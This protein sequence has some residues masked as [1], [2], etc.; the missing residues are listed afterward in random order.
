MQPEGRLFGMG[1]MRLSTEPGR[2]EDR[3]VAVLQAALEAGVTLLDTADAYCHDET[4]AGHNERLI[5]RALSTWRGEVARIRVAT[6]GGLTRPGGEWVPDGRARHLRAACQRSRQA[7]GVE[8]IDLYLLHAPDP[9]T[10]LKTSVRA[11]AALQAE[12]WIREIGLCNVTVRQIEEAR[13]IAAIRAVQVEMSPW[14]EASF[15]NG[16]AEHC[17]AHGIPLLAHRPLGGVAGCARLDRDPVVREVATRHGATPQEIALAWL[18]DLSPALVPLPG[19]TRVETAR[20]LA[21]AYGLQLT[22]ED[23]HALDRRFPASRL[24]RRSRDERRPAEGASGDVVLVMGLPAAGKSTVAE[25]LVRDGYARLNRDQTGGRLAGLLP[26]LDRTLAAGQRRIV[27]DNTYGSRAVRNAVIETAWAHGVPVRC[28]WLDTPIED[29]Q[30]N[31]AGRLLSR[32]GRLLEPEE[33][34]RAAG[35]DP[36]AFGPGAQFR[37]VR[38]LEPPSPDEGFT[39]IDVLPF[40]RRPRSNA[41][42]TRALVLWYDVLRHSR[43]GRRTPVSPEDVELLP[44]RSEVLQR[45]AD[46]GWLLLGLSWHPE[47]AAG[48]TTREAVEAGFARTQELIGRS[49]DVRYCPHAEGPPVCWCRKPLPGLGLVLIERHR[50]DPERCLY[51][52][53]HATDRAFAQRLGFAYRD[54][55]EVFGASNVPR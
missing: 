41:S 1:G 18:L 3:A 44:G 14:Q 15:R 20:S 4:E 52:G 42:E 33:M 31:A 2:D 24:L 29:A 7:L 12:G 49:V 50:L 19:P 10:P 9:R 30:V 53:H 47:I 17:I 13:S 6:K 27:L 54:A 21:R 28:L 40:Q 38:E 22:D 48:H 51:V 45:Y 55:S 8:T 36:G 23:R 32:Y 16:V 34:Q 35:D 11:L 46:E 25:D 43:S 5:R 37:Y 26:L 39:R